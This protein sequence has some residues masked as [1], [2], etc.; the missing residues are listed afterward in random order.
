MNTTARGLGAFAEP[1]RIG[2]EDAG[3]E[4]HGERCKRAVMVEIGPP[5]SG[6]RSFRMT[7]PSTSDAFSGLR[8][9][10]THEFF[11]RITKVERSDFVDLLTTAAR[12]GAIDDHSV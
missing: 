8:K 1:G 5:K 4:S 11:F 9:Q 2:L 3:G 6:Y 12:R 7:L 10:P